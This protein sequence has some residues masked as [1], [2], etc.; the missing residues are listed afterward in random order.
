MGEILLAFFAFFGKK[1][2]FR[3]TDDTLS[4]VAHY[5]PIHFHKYHLSQRPIP[6]QP[7]YITSPAVTRN[8]RYPPSSSSNIYN[9]NQNISP[10]DGQSKRNPYRQGGT[11]TSY[12]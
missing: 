5:N 9:F 10:K 4:Y 8:G 7:V 1:H 11:I 2:C 12:F 3:K 6:G